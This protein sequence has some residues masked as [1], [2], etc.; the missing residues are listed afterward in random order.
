MNILLVLATGN[1]NYNVKVMNEYWE[2]SSRL[3]FVSFNKLKC[4]WGVRNAGTWA[5]RMILFFCKN[6]KCV[7]SVFC[8]PLYAKPN[9]RSKQELF[10]YRNLAPKYLVRSE[11]LLT[12]CCGIVSIGRYSTNSYR[13]QCLLRRFDHLNKERMKGRISTSLGLHSDHWRWAKMMQEFPEVTWRV[14]GRPW[15][16]S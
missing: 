4:V 1:V 16:N 9:L 2:R 14:C 13:K 11:P 12:T 6:M 15:K 7:K 3:K 10:L 5:F 8:G